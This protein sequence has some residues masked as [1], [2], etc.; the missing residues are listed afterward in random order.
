MLFTTCLCFLSPECS[1]QGQALC[2]PGRWFLR[3]AAAEWGEAAIFHLLPPDQGHYGKKSLTVSEHS[4]PALRPCSLQ[5]LWEKL[6]SF[7]LCPSLG[8]L[9]LP[10][11]LCS[12]VDSALWHSSMASGPH[13]GCN[14]CCSI[15][16]VTLSAPHMLDVCMTGQ[17]ISQVTG[18]AVSLPLSFG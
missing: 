1:P 9:C 7:Q 10:V 8:S 14:Q 6:P 17:C 16:A 18:L 15:P 3:V 2:G 13:P 5:L 12:V 11:G 4:Q